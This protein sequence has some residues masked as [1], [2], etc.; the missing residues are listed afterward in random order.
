MPG[1]VIS[2]IIF[3]MGIVGIPPLNGFVSKFIICY[4]AVLAEKAGLAFI[5]CAVSIVSCGY[6]F[7]VIQVLFAK[8]QRRHNPDFRISKSMRVPVYV[9]A[10]LCVVLGLFPSLVLHAVQVIL[11]GG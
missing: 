9:L 8:K 4:G 1:L 11:G 6:Y 5:I 3:S 2:F 10:F 7:R